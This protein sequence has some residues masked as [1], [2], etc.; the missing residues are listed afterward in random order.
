M[1]GPIREPAGR[2]SSGNGR[3][4][5]F[6]IDECLSPKLALALSQEGHYAEH[7]RD[8]GNLGV[9]DHVVLER[10]LDLNLV[11]VTHNAG[12]FRKLAGTTDIHPGN[13]IME[14]VPYEESLVLMRS[15]IKH[16]IAASKAPDDYMVNR[17]IEISA[18]SRIKD[19]QLPAA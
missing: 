7:P 4:V 9:S 13:I 5:R 18:S 11:V 14:E 2:R 8:R 12:D 19:Y 17:V 16:V 6:L 3:H 15:V 1:R 10:C